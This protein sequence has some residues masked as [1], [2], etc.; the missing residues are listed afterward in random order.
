MLAFSGAADAGFAPDAGFAA[1]AGFAIDARAAPPEIADFDEAPFALFDA[2]FAVAFDAL[3]A[4]FAAE[5]AAPFA[6]DFAPAFDVPF[7]ASFAADFAFVFAAEFATDLPAPFAADFAA[8][9]AGAAFDFT[10]AFGAGFDFAFLAAAVFVDCAIVVS[11]DRR[12]EIGNSTPGNGS[13]PESCPCRPPTTTHV[14]GVT[15]IVNT[16]F[17]LALAP[18]EPF[19]TTCSDGRE[20]AYALRDEH[21]GLEYF[22][23]RE[24]PI[25]LGWG[26]DGRAK[27]VLATRSARTAVVFPWVDAYGS[28]H[29]LT[30]AIVERDAVVAKND[31]LKTTSWDIE[32]IAIRATRDGWEVDY[33]QADD[34]PTETITLDLDGNRR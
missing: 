29:A 24:T 7:A 4:D 6:A 16:V 30:I 9:L 19:E 12:V 27:C 2:L 23:A 17:L 26:Y 21:T 34:E 33:R 8:A 28:R 20:L 25:R 32:P 14:V 13:R 10:G 15:R 5:F 22:L 3:F 1:G 18:D 11:P 31:F